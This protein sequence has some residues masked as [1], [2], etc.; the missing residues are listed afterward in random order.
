MSTFSI[1]N[2]AAVHARSADA[3]T[4]D[5]GG[6]GSLGGHHQPDPFVALKYDLDDMDAPVLIAKGQDFLTFKMREVA[7]E[8]G[9]PIVENP[10]IARALYANVDVD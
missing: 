7:E 6:A 3:P 9:I 5:G 2:A 4:H 8:N 1:V 10:P